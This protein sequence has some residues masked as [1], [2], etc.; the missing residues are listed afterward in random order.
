MSPMGS[1]GF[2]PG[3][4]SIISAPGTSGPE[5]AAGIMRPPT[6]GVFPAPLLLACPGLATS[7]PS[8]SC[9]RVEL[10]PPSLVQRPRASR[11]SSGLK[12]D[13]SNVSARRA[14]IACASSSAGRLRCSVVIIASAR[15]PLSRA[16]AMARA[17]ASVAPP[18]APAPE[19]LAQHEVELGRR[20]RREAEERPAQQRHRSDPRA[21]RVA[22]HAIFVR[23]IEPMA[24]PRQ[25]VRCGP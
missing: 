17:P 20:P 19:G 1:S 13:F 6:S 11:G 2:V 8:I 15:S 10:P 9:C 18:F 16:S 14:R 4:C 5:A 22:T 3:R 7:R 25:R 12:P 21:V 24:S 23:R